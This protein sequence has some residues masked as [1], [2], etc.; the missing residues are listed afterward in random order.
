MAT[1]DHVARI[2]EQIAESTRATR[3]AVRGDVRARLRTETNESVLAERLGQRVERAVLT[4]FGALAVRSIA[5][6]GFGGTL[7]SARLDYAL[8]QLG[9]QFAAVMKPVFD[10]MTYAAAEVDRRFRTLNGTEQNRLLG[11]AL[12]AGIGLRYGGLLGALAGGAV[13]S[14]AM[15]EGRPTGE[16]RLMGIGAGAYAG[17]RLG[18]LPGAVLGGAAGAVGT[19]GDYARMREAGKSRFAS[20]VVSLAAGMYEAPHTLFGTGPAPLDEAR[21]RWDDRRPKPPGPEPHRDVTPFSA[22]PLAAGGT[23]DLVQ[24][25]LIR[26]TAGEGFEESSPF[27]PVIDAIMMVFDVLMKIWTGGSYTPPPR[28]ATAAR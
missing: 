2:L 13:G 6:R 25:A 23:A 15:A 26:A 28:S 11:T 5:N 19:S 27:R 10:G 8:E 4:G 24:K 9:R 14:L 12:G 3:D 21:R 7:E 20:G 17:F 16:D 18:G 1:L 22:D